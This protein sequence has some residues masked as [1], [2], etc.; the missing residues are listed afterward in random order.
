MSEHEEDTTSASAE[1]KTVPSSAVDSTLGATSGAAV[2]AVLGGV[3]AGPIGAVTGA[4]VGSAV[5][6]VMGFWGHKRGTFL[7]RRSENPTELPSPAYHID[8]TSSATPRV[9]LTS[10]VHGNDALRDYLAQH[11]FVETQIL[12]ALDELEHTGV[13]SLH[14]PDK[15]ARPATGHGTVKWFNDE[16]G[17]GFI[18]QDDGQDVFVHYSAIEPSGFKSL[19]EGDPVEFEVARGTKGLQAQSVRKVNVRGFRSRQPHNPK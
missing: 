12:K 13:T 18:S 8:Y 17:Y 9:S 11:G 4:V 5:G 15:S 6:A 16:K 7:I 1:E 10:I 3:V 2:G 14:E 19:N